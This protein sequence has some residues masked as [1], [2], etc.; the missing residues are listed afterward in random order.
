MNYYVIRRKGTDRCMPAFAAHGSTWALPTNQHP[1]RLVRSRGGAA[2]SLTWWLRGAVSEFMRHE[3]DSKYTTVV[4]KR[5][6]RHA[7]DME[8]VEV[9]VVEVA[10]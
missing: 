8:V 5:S 4:E 2:S 9:K 7:E 10:T 6:E 3:E 1:P